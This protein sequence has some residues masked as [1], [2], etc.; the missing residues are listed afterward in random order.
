MLV[1][2]N[3][4][5]VLE[6]TCRLINILVTQLTMLRIAGSGQEPFNPGFFVQ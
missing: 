2:A 5:I 4:I 6:M 1:T 3:V